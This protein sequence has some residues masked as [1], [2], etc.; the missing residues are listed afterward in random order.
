MDFSFFTTDNKS[1]YKTTEK[2]VSKNLPE[3]FN[4]IINFSIQSESIISFKERLWLFFHNQNCR[5]K[6]KNCGK[7][8]KFRNRLDLPYGEFCTIEC[9]N[10]NK[11]EIISRQKITF[12]K[13][14]NVDFYPQHSDF[15]KKQQNTKLLKYGDKNFNNF[16]KTKQ[17]KLQKYGDKNYNNLE[18]YKKTCLDHY[19]SENYSKSEDFKKNNNLKYSEL[20]PEL[21][22]EFIGDGYVIF[23]CEKCN[24][25]SEITK[26]L[27]YERHKRNYEVCTICNP[28]GNRNRSNYEKEICGFLDEK[29]IKYKTNDKV[30]SNKVEI[31]ILLIDYSIGIEI[32]GVYWHNELFK[33]SNFHLKKT[34]Y[35]KENNIELIHIF[36]DEWVY[37]KEIVKS[38]ILNRIGETNNKFYARNCEIKEVSSNESKLF[39][40][41]NHIQGNV[42]SKIRIGLYQKGNLIS[43][44]TFSKGRILMG[45]KDTEWE[46][47]RFCNLIGIRVVGGASKLLK[48]FIEKYKPN[49]IVSYSDI[50]I[51]GGEMY[52][53]LGF[54]FVSKSKPNY[55]YVIN[56]MRHHRFNFRKSVLVKKGHNSTKTEKEI[57]FELKHY[58]IY[59]C[60]NIRWEYNLIKN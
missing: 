48:F 52:K 28:L 46:L 55:W 11:E 13:K 60:G 16:E 33:D 45:G 7:E 59:D 58:R 4:S 26:Q 24:N 47:N 10:S 38:I 20:Y 5:P 23:K 39:L 30:G 15:L 44:M 51:F 42:N 29:S 50:R 57:M 14:Y 34:E 2:W 3:L 56:G 40:E 8:V 19:G 41:N 9:F 27:V 54:E 18:K 22:F 37:K 35:C 25:S 43:L 31:D 17:T 53:S 36:E 49:K 6:C 1:G 32:D 12:Q 21:N